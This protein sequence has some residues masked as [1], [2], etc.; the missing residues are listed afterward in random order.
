MNE[1]LIYIYALLFYLQYRYRYFENNQKRYLLKYWLKTR[2]AIREVYDTQYKRA[3][4]EDIID[5]VTKDDYINAFLKKT[6]PTPTSS[7]EYKE[8]AEDRLIKIIL[9][10]LFKQWAEYDSPALCQMAFNYLSVPIMSSEN[11]RTFSDTRLIISDNRIRLGPDIIEALECL[12][13]W[14]KGGL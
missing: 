6:L 14:K 13:H 10:N 9:P 8:Y 5:N 7:D 3:S 12:H 11:E 1:T 2:K 4:A